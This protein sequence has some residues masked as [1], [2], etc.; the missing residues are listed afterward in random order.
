LFSAPITQ[1]LRENAMLARDSGAGFCV[2]TPAALAEV[3][4]RLI[5]DPKDCRAR[6]FAAKRFLAIHRGSALRVAQWIREGVEL[7]QEECD[8]P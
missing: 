4:V 5:A 7:N 1:N 6:G 8:P 2:A 3:V